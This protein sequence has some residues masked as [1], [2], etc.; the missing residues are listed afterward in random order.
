MRIVELKLMLETTLMLIKAAM[1]RMT[2][3]IITLLRIRTALS[4]GPEE[5]PA[6][7]HVAVEMINGLSSIGFTVDHKT[8]SLFATALGLR[9]FLGFHKEAPQKPRIGTFSFHD[10]PYMPL[11]YNKEMHRRLGCDVV[12]SEE[13]IILVNLL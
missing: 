9:E 6:A 13:F 11:W 7:K 1:M 2:A 12:E 4:R 5:G 10:V 3:G 8:R